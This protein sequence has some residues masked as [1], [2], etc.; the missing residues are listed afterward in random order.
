MAKAA[1]GPGNLA[2]TAYPLTPHTDNPYRNP[3][4]GVQ[5]LHSIVAAPGGG[6]ESLLVDGFAVAERLRQVRPTDRPRHGI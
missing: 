5:L 6:G 1:D 3:T 4:P 2:Y